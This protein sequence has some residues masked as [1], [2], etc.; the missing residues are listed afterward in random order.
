LGAALQADGGNEVRICGLKHQKKERHAWRR[1]PPLRDTCVNAVG[2][3]LSPRT[4]A[5]RPTS[6]HNAGARTRKFPQTKL[7][8]KRAFFVRADL[9]AARKIKS[10]QPTRW[11]GC[12]ATTGSR[13]AASISCRVPVTDCVCPICTPPRAGVSERVKWPS[14][15]VCLAVSCCSMLIGARME[16]EVKGSTHSRAK[17]VRIRWLLGRRSGGS[18]NVLRQVAVGEGPVFGDSRTGD[19]D[20]RTEGSR[21]CRR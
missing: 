14:A 20:G 6:I 8:T 3:C 16:R 21:P 5:M 18:S 19:L 1:R 10:P 9:R 2:Y 17:N 4:G 11:R 12:P 7:Q 15:R 13:A